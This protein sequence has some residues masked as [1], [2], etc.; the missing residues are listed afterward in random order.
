MNFKFKVAFVLFILLVLPLIVLAQPIVGVLTASWPDC[1]E[2][3][4]DVMREAGFI[5]SMQDGFTDA[6]GVLLV[7][8]DSK[9]R[10]FKYFSSVSDL[11]SDLRLHNTVLAIYATGYNPVVEATNCY[12]VCLFSIGKR[13]ELKL[14]YHQTY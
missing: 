12:H 5:R 3:A 4:S 2:I 6:E 7:T 8:Y 10:E 9:I 14:E 1:R 13:G 11:E